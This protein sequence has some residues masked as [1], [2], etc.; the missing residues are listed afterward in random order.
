MPR[1]SLIELLLGHRPSYVDTTPRRSA[2]VG[3]GPVGTRDD[4][5]PQPA[6]VAAV[7]EPRV[8]TLSTP[9][10]H[11]SLPPAPPDYT[12]GI[13]HHPAHVVLERERYGVTPLGYSRIAD[14]A[15]LTPLPPH[16]NPAGT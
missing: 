8:T 9:S 2:T 14:Q 4:A 5:R 12:P 15:A 16:N 3:G 7:P 11:W 13:C 10:A 1:A 6:P